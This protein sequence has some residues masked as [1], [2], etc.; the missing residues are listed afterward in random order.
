MSIDVLV[1]MLII[2]VSL[3]GVELPFVDAGLLVH[4]EFLLGISPTEFARDLS[5]RGVG[6]SLVAAPV[7]LPGVFL[8]LVDCFTMRV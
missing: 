1:S 8:T 5:V 2:D 4:E 7:L 6:L 3:R